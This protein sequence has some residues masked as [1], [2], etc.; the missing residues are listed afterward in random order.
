MTVF[1]PAYDVEAPKCLPA[2]RKIV[3]VHRRFDV[4]ATF[5]IV[6]KMLEANPSE[7]RELLSDSA[8]EVASHS[9]SHKMLRDHP[10][11]G[12]A[13]STEQVKTEIFKG[14]ALVENVFN[15]L[16]LGLRPGCG[17][18]DGLKGAPEL[19]WLV[20]KAGYRYVSS[21]LWG[22]DFSMPAPLNQPFTYSSE[23]YPN[24][25][26]F[27]GHGWHENVFK[28]SSAKAR[29]ILLF[30]PLYPEM[31]PSSFVKTP[32]EEFRFNNRPMIDHAMSEHAMYVSLVWHPWSLNAF[33][34]EMK[35]LEM[36][37]EYLKK[38]GVQSM[39]FSEVLS[40]LSK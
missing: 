38:L 19:L 26:E 15:R 17:F 6:G 3:E 25:W 33:D 27:P 13:A 22:P 16:C 10:I 21:M 37:F 29:R 18:V 8:F 32:L 9:Y 28:I 35:M 39:S 34:P 31:V 20:S 23:G 4:P 24:L 2:C 7:Y 36:T 1:V 30:P 14:K 5:F 11:C 40:L 12:P